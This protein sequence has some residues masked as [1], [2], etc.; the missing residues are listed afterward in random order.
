M[1]DDRRRMSDPANAG[2]CRFCGEARVLTRTE[3]LE[4]RQWTDRGYVFCKV[5]IPIDT[6]DGCGSR[7]WSEAAEAVIDRAVRQ[8]YDKLS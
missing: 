5:Q 2:T 3:W 7:T 6:C 4:F 8:E 1:A